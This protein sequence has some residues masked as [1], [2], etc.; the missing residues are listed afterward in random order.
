MKN[1]QIGRNTA[2]AYGEDKEIANYWGNR[3]NDSNK[4]GRITPAFTG[5]GPSF[6]VLHADPSASPYNKDLTDLYNMLVA[7]YPPDEEEEVL[8]FDSRYIAA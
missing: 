7:N 3:A 8:G 4:V 5:Y 6:Y 1:S 2:V